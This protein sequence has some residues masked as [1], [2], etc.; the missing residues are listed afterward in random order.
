VQNAGF[1]QRNVSLHFH[2][3]IMQPKRLFLLLTLAALHASMYGQYACWLHFTNKNGTYG[4]LA[5]PTGYLSQRAI[6]RRAK[7][8]IAIDSTDLP[9]ST[10]YVQAVINAGG[11]IKSRSKWLNGLT[12][13]MPDT[14]LLPTLRALPFVSAVTLTQTPA[15]AQNT[16]LRKTR[17]IVE[18]VA[19]DY[20]NADRQIDMHNGRQLH[21]M[22]YRGAGMMIGILDAGFY[23]AD[24]L[25]VFDSLRIQNRL[26]GTKDFADP[27]VPF[28]SNTESHGMAVLS[29]MA[30][31]W[32]GY[33]RGTAPDASYWLIRTEYSPSEYL[34]ETDNWVA[35]IE[36]A[37]SLGVDVVNSSLGYTT[38]DNSKMNFTYQSMNGR[39]SRASIA[40]TMAARK[41]MI[42]VSAAGNE[43]NG[44]WHYISSPADADSILTVGAVDYNGAHA[45]FSGYGPTADGRIKPDV[46]AVGLQTVIASTSNTITTGNGT[47]FASPIMAGLTACLWQ[48]LPDLKNMQIINLIRQFS[49]YAGSPDNTFGYGIPDL[50]AAYRYATTTNSL[51]FPGIGGVSARIYNESLI[52]DSKDGPLSRTTISLF[53]QTGQLLRHWENTTLPARLQINGLPPGFYLV[54][55]ASDSNRQTC[56]IIKQ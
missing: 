3:Y 31:D 33:M 51:S 8:H 48:A 1:Y 2:V 12:I 17:S 42:V 5:S 52:I 38:F 24:Q 22:G 41:G 35:G 37:D 18:T 44:S 47:S 32:P 55:I 56:K 15:T 30:A 25:T 9:L 23:K 45:A 53:S 21:S 49:S 50:Y 36:F 14:T 11:V 4:K 20:G 40:A 39:T 29:T 43:G 19:G 34:V 16:P 10:A 6:D 28:F 54:H 26:L 13:T 7:Q 46:C 27:S